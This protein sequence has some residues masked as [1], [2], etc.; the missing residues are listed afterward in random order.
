[1]NGGGVT[2]AYSGVHQAYQIA[3]AAHE[4][5]LLDG[6]YCSIVDAAGKWG[7]ILSRVGGRHRLIT[8]RIDSI[9]SNK[10]HEC[11]TPWLYQMAIARLFPGLKQ[12]W[13]K[14]NDHFDKYVAKRL[15]RS[16]S[17][18][19]VG[20]ETCAARSFAA[21]KQLGMTLVLECP[22]VDSEY[23]DERASL[24]ASQLGL[25]I[26]R[27]ADSQGM[28][29]RKDAELNLADRVIVCSEYQ[30]TTMERRGVDPGKFS[31]MPLWVDSAFWNV[32]PRHQPSSGPL[33]VLY[34]GRI[35]LRK[36]IPYLLQAAQAC[37]G[38]VGL[39]LVGSIDRDI[40][41]LLQTASASASI[42]YPV[43][44]SRL[45]EF[46][47]ENDLLVLPTLGDAFGFVALE[48]MACGL[49]VVV[50]ENCGVPVPDPAWRVPVMD[51]EAIAAR[52][53]MYAGN[54][55]ALREDGERALHFARQFTP[56]RYRKGIGTALHRFLGQ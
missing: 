50:T 29:E 46:Y 55:V 44:K 17:S 33:R 6:F 18:L 14:A 2:V 35:S 3:C 4:A 28:R 20:V 22:G 42:H 49:P 37:R 56:E 9:P 41:P 45:R 38:A 52:L 43:C 40:S 13:L 8:R 32:G 30:K 51:A 12:D 15:E 21:A 48:A 19:F 11:P 25:S 24:A 53:E 1:M 26:E 23:L 16:R 54:R 39:T 31:V 27:S 47:A 5:G 7:R 36:G 34:A 10:L